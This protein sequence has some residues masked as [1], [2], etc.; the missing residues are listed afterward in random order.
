MIEMIKTNFDRLFCYW[1][2]DSLELSKLAQYKYL[3]KLF[4]PLFM[5]SFQIRF[6][7]ISQF[8]FFLNALLSYKFLGHDWKMQILIRRSLLKINNQNI[9]F[10]KFLH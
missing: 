9:T 4:L 10:A 3:I 2:S 1:L 5:S 6:L 7:F 8:S